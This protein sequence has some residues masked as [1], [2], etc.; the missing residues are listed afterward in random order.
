M[1]N[2]KVGFSFSKGIEKGMNKWGE[3]MKKYYM[4]SCSL[5]LLASIY[6]SEFDN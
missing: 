2:S 5:A 4:D 6:V 3:I 1:R